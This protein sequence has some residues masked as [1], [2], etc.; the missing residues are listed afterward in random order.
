MADTIP[1]HNELIT[2]LKD[3]NLRF[4]ENQSNPT[5]REHESIEVQR[6]FAIVLGCSDS[7]VPPETVFDQGIGDLFVI[8]VAGNIVT[9]IELGGIEFASTKC[10]S[11]LVV[12]LGHTQCGAVQAAHSI[13]HDDAL[14]V[15]TLSDGLGAIVSQVVPSV[16]IGSDVDSA[17]RANI[18]NSVDRIRSS[19]GSVGEQIKSGSLKVVGALYHI[20]SGKVEFFDD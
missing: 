19:D 17:V 18:R 16:E 15:S 6:P 20:E 13:S 4:L 7:R 3:G 8:R 11:S 9:P 14:D 1:N 12:V 2:R 5:N 10:G